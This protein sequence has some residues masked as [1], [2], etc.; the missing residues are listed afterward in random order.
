MDR[1][2]TMDCEKCKAHIRREVAREIFDW[3]KSKQ[4]M[5][6]EIP[7]EG[8]G[9]QFLG[10]YILKWGKTDEPTLGLTRLSEDADFQA[11][12]ARYMGEGK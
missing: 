4:L 7:E 2:V 9:Y 11:L 12:K 8:K 3:I 5:V 10:C 6:S 1:Q